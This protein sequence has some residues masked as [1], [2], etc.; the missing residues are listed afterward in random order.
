MAEKPGAEVVRDFHTYADTDSDSNAIHHTLGPG[1][2]QAAPGSH[3]HR[4]SD[5]A[6]LF[7]GITI[8]GSRGGNTA[9]SSIIAAL[10]EFGAT[11]ST[12]A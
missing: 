1:N 9:I 12:T 3:S 8:T 7:E 10:V 5:S 2:H 4:G 11:D 6:L